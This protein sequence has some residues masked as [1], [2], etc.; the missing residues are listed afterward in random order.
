MSITSQKALNLPSETINDDLK[1]ELEF[2]NQALYAAKEGR[3]RVLAAKVPFSRPEDFFAEMV[4]TDVHMT[5]V[6]EKLIN[7]AQAIKNA[8]E[9]KKMREL[10][11]F[12]K[13]V[14]QEKLLERQKQKSAELE[15]IKLARKK[16]QS[17]GANVGQE[18]DD[19]GVE[20]NADE[21][22]KPRANVKRQRKDAKYGFGGGKRFKKSNT[23][24]STN[25]MSGFS[26][27]KM[28]KA[29]PKR[30]GKSRRIKSRK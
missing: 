24:E 8:A 1:R 15:K 13:K 28:K 6:R 17:V 3:R 7:E 9:A 2:Y 25:D 27:K 10:K 4:K 20:L 12:G 16:K 30:L 18:D 26:V 21:P 11:K 29:A 22:K 5:K 19:F 14:Q 23:A